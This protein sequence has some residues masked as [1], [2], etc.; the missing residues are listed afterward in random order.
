MSTRLVHDL[1]YQ[2]PVDAV[3]AMLADPAFREEVCAYQRMKHREVAIERVGE[4]LH[5]TIDQWRPTAGLPSFA[6]KIVGDETNIVQKEIWA[7]PL[8]GDIAIS[9]PGTP[10]HI[11]GTARIEERGQLTVET[12]DLTVKVGIPLLGGRL[13]G[14]VEELLLAALRAENEVGRA[15]L[16]R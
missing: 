5:V 16:S 3:T 15:Y 12:V 13:E 7:S 14:V 1:T 2:A 8:V 9:I 6:R 11:N 10:G 4:V